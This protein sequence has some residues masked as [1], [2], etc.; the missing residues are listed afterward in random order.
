MSVTTPQA[1]APRTPSGLLSTRPVWLV[2]ILATLAGAVVTEAFALVARAAG[3]PMEAA[4]PGAT[5]A[6]EIPVGGF[7]GG[8]VFWSVAGIVLA[9]VLARWARQPARTFTVTTVA[10]TALSLAGP[11]VAPHTATST[12]IVLAASHVVAAAVV[13]PLLARRLSYVR[14]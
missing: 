11:A 12:Q 9:V 1:Q 14:R 10:L 2:G 6:A 8:V 5:E 13:V 7:F 4:S 3:V